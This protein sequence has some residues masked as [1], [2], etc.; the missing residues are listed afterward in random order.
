[1]EFQVLMDLVSDTLL[2]NASLFYAS[3]LDKF[4][5]MGS[6]HL[7]HKNQLVNRSL[8]CIGGYNCQACY[9]ICYSNKQ[10]AFYFWGSGLCYSVLD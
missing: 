5:V 2:V 1:M 6:Y 9:W 10:N 4:L 8:Q 3:S 7:Q